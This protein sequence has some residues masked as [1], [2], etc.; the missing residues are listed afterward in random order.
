MFTN[1]SWQQYLVGLGIV[2]SLY[3]LLLL[4]WSTS[5]NG[6]LKRWARFT[7]KG[8]TSAN[9]ESSDS[10]EADSLLTSQTSNSLSNCIDELQVFFTSVRNCADKNMI[11]PKL[12]LILQKHKVV[13]HGLD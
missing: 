5:V 11:V 9:L 7:K 12:K 3:Y 1:I 8:T 6:N 13:K 10:L 2:T 4:I